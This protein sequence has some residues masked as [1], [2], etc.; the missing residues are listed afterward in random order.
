MMH[1]ALISLSV[2]TVFLFASYL[3]FITA[4]ASEDKTQVDIPKHMAAEFLDLK[5]TPH[6]LGQW[7]GEVVLV[8][9]WATWCA[10]CR[11]EI[12]ELSGIKNKFKDKG[13]AVVG[14]A[15]DDAD[16][17]RAFMKQGHAI[18]YQILVGDLDAMPYSI[19]LGN[20]S[21]VVPYTVLIDRSGNIAHAY[22]GRIKLD[23]IEADI[24][25]L[26]QKS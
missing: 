15:L 23:Q 22:Y 6:T 9:F 14:I 7:N 3:I 20:R 17:I 10:P 1:R 13:V 12:P 21:M 11:E 19:S 4:F 16:K 26:L 25:K 24:T 8:N 2:L 5:G 18:D